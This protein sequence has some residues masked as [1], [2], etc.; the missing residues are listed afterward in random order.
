VGIEKGIRCPLRAN[1]YQKKGLGKAPLSQVCFTTTGEK[2]DENQKRTHL[3]R[4]LSQMKLPEHVHGNSKQG[5]NTPQPDTGKVT[6]A[7]T[8]SQK[9]GHGDGC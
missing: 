4:K 1:L 8:Y 2:I 6:E 7:L 3:K 5:E 9:E